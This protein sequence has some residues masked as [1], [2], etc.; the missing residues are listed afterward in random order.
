MNAITALA[1][2]AAMCLTAVLVVAA[3]L[4][5][6]SSQ[7]AGVADRGVLTASSHQMA[8]VTAQIAAQYLMLVGK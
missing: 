2:R 5:G 7:I 3:G 1:R 6:C 8:D 4:V